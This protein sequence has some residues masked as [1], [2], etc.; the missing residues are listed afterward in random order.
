MSNL[1]Y[2]DKRWRYKTLAQAAGTFVFVLLAQASADLADEVRRVCPILLADSRALWWLQQ[3]SMAAIVMLPS[4]LWWWIVRW[5][6][7]KKVV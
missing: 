7:D 6:F 4:L 5:Y 1:S 2:D 3:L